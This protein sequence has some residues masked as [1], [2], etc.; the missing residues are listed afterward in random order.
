[1]GQEAEEHLNRAGDL[2]RDSLREARRSVQALRPLA[3]EEKE[4]WEALEESIQKMTAGTAVRA[5]FILQGEPQEL[6]PEWEENLLRIGQEVM[7]N[8]LRHAQASHFKTQITFTP[9]EVHLELCDNGLGFD[10]SS[11]Y[12]GFGLLGIKERVEGM[13]GRLNL[14]SGL[15]AGT[16]I[17]IVLPLRDNSR[18]CES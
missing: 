14:K 12:D 7:T 2:A 11:E 6:P 13:G 3:L 5:E 16:A 15:G 17:L 18:T 8:V 10:P 1:L 9:G 4:L